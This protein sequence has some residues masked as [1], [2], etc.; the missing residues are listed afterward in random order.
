MS[1][2]NQKRTVFAPQ[3]ALV[4]SSQVPANRVISVEIGDDED[5]EWLWISLPD[6]TKYVSGYTVVPKTA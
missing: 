1:E 4:S 6:G 2:D 5:V 3:P